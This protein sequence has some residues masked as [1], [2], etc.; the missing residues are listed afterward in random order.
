MNLREHAAGEPLDVTIVG[1]LRRKHRKV[2]AAEPGHGIGLFHAKGYAG[3]GL[4]EDLIALGGPDGIVDDLEA[5]E[6]DAD[7]RANEILLVR[8][9]Q[10]PRQP[11]LEQVSVRKLGERIVVCLPEQQAPGLIG[12]DQVHGQGQKPGRLTLRAR[13][14]HPGYLVGKCLARL[15]S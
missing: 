1:S 7:E 10:H 6:I 3:T 9:Q 2:I 12:T 15:V 5:I 4:H 8:P 14:N 11:L 13:E